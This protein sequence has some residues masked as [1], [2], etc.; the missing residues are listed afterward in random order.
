MAVAA[1]CSQFRRDL[2][3]HERRG[4]SSSRSDEGWSG[5][6]ERTGSVSSGW[7]SLRNGEFWE[8]KAGLK[9]LSSLLSQDIVGVLDDGLDNVDGISSGT[10]STGHLG[11]HLGHGSAKSG[12][13]VFFVHVD[14]ISSSLVF[15]DDSVVLDG[16][17]FSLEDLA[18][19]NDLSLALSDLV[20]SLHLIPELGSSEHD[21]LGEDSDSITG[22]L[23]GG[24]AWK[25]SSDNPKLLDLNTN[26][27]QNSEISMRSYV[28]VY[29]ITACNLHFSAWRQL[30]HL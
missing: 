30:R 16:L 20:L 9:I 3:P 10:V 11:V 12:G 25:L 14:D 4:L 24:L 29:Q 22:W 7:G 13:S 27:S 21:V 26:Y 18:D 8:S 28:A 1:N 2:L 19:I 15:K 5:G 6:S 23:W 17:S